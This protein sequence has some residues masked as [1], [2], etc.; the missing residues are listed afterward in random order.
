MKITVEEKLKHI[1]RGVIITN[2]L[3]KKYKYVFMCCGGIG[4]TYY[5]LKYIDRFVIDNDYNNIE[6]FIPKSH[7]D[8]LNIVRPTKIRIHSYNQK[9]SLDLYYLLAVIN[10]IDRKY[11]VRL[12]QPVA[13]RENYVDLSSKYNIEQIYYKYVFRLKGMLPENIHRKEFALNGIERKKILIIPDSNSVYPIPVIFW[14]ELIVS[15]QKQLVEKVYVNYTRYRELYEIPEIIKYDKSIS[16]LFNEAC[17]FDCVISIRNGIC[18]LL[19][20][21]DTNLIILYPNDDNYD[22][23]EMFSLSMVSGKSR[24]AE[25]GFDRKESNTNNIKKIM[26]LFESANKK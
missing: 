1:C 14:K 5:V 7:I 22:F 10:R 25:V 17:N 9:Y 19:A 20:K 24:I 8:L 2:K 23:K 18:D 16:E 6:L 13:I 26:K 3:M 15:L 4:D 12:L 11:R 21:A